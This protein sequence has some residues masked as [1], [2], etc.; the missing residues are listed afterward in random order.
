MNAPHEDIAGQA[1]K[2]CLAVLCSAFILIA[3]LIN[4]AADLVGAFS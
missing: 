1:L 2:G 3:A 4:G